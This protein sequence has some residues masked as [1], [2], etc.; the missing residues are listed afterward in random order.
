MRGSQGSTPWLSATRPQKP[1]KAEAPATWTF[2]GAPDVKT[3]SERTQMSVIHSTCARSTRTSVAW[4]GD[5]LQHFQ[6]R[7]L[8]EALA[9]AL[10]SYWAMRAEQ[11][12]AAA[13]R[14][15]DYHGN[16][17]K[18]ELDAAC[19]R[20]MNLAELCRLH[21]ELLAEA[22]PQQYLDEVD[23]VLGEAA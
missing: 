8:Q 18:E 17:T 21:G 15:G 22:L 9:A 14:P 12:H 10:P 4:L 23:D 19:R 20:C 7:F 16:A 6:R 1:A 2:A 3:R 5:H 13:P 11:F